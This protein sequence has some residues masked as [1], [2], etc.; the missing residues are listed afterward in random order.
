MASSTVCCQR[1]A[2][3]TAG[4]RNSCSIR[5]NWVASMAASHWASKARGRAS[6]NSSEASSVSGVSG[7][8]LWRRRSVSSLKK[9]VRGAKPKSAK[10]V[11]TST[12]DSS[13]CHHARR[14]C[15]TSGRASIAS[16]SSCKRPM[17]AC[18]DGCLPR[19]QAHRLISH[20]WR[21][22]S[23]ACGSSWSS[24][25]PRSVWPAFNGAPVL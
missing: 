16:S 4:W 7:S 10:R 8:S 14:R 18:G 12:V 21:S 15:C 22:A 9:A 19:I 13:T 6:E 2:P 20:R 23:G 11:V 25:L 1:V 24:R 5:C 3:S 17:A